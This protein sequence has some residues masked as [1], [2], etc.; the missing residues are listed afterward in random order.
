MKGF[1]PMVSILVAAV[2]AVFC[3][4][5]REQELPGEKKSRVIAAENVQLKQ[6]LARRDQEIAKLNAQHEKQ[7][8]QQRG[9]LAKCVGLKEALEKQLQ[10]NVKEQVESVL[11]EVVEESAKL[12]QQIKELKA[13]IE[14]MRQQIP[15]KPK[16]VEAP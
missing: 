5:C 9:E 8:K 6:E 15:V 14:K 4:S 1:M 10:Q 12:Q 11:T 7:M 2:I 16:P 3:A 13:E